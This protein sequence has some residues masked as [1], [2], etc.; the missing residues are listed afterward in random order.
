MF[1][2]FTKMIVAKP[3]HL[4]SGVFW[5]VKTTWHLLWPSGNSICVLASWE[6]LY[7]L[8]IIGFIAL[9]SF[10]PFPFLVYWLQ[11]AI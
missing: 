9:F 7:S 2:D 5:L 1:E 6:T 3:N 4:L 11:M 8:R 10:V